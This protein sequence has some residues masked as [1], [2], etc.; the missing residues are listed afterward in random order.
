MLQ[1]LTGAQSRFV[2]VLAI[3]VSVTF[4]AHAQDIEPRAYANTPI[5]LNFLIAGYGYTGGGVAFDPSLPIQDAKVRVDATIFAYA[6][7]LELMGKSGKF[8]IVVPYAW[9][10]GSA[11]ALGQFHDRQISGFADPQMR[12][13]INL[14]GA[15][16]LSMKD[17]ASY[18]QDTI[19]GVSLNVTAPGGQ[20]DSTKLLNIGTNRWSIKP[21]IGI[22]K[23]LGRLTLELDG[24]FVSNPTTKTFLV[25]TFV[26]RNPCI[27]FKGI[28]F[29]ALAMA[30]GLR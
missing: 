29:I 19:L 24:A 5:G 30:Y 17:F 6:S 9:V 26:L 8:D 18:Q 2:C 1:I 28:S 16:A 27:L 13:S 21:E 3:L 4:A 20:Y 7:S 12:F 15:P 14:L 22:S 10:D 23:R 25:T 11:T